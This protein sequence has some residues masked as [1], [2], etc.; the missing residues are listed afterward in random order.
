[1]S[2]TTREALNRCEPNQTWDRLRIL[3]LGNILAGNVAHHLRRRDPAASPYTDSS[4][5]AIT[6]PGASKGC[7][8]LRGTS[9]VGGVTGELT[10]VAY[11]VTPGTGEIAVAP[12]GDIVTLA[13]DAIT[14][15]DVS[16]MPERGDEIELVLPVDPATGFCDIPQRYVDRGVILLTEAEVTAGTL[17]QAMEILVPASS[18]P[19]STNA[20]LS[21]PKSRVHFAVADAATEARIKLLL[22]PIAAAD[23]SL[24]LPATAT[25]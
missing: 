9:L 10:P 20:R 4:L 24:A 13:A 22:A 8:V 14:S 11:G 5:L 19:A 18:A 15:L 12:N 6:L 25:F 23:L 1:M 2:E 17:E 7:V 3:E 16:Y 21:L